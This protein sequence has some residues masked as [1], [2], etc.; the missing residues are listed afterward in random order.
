MKASFTSSPKSGGP[1]DKARF[2]EGDPLRDGAGEGWEG[3]IGMSVTFLPR[4]VCLNATS[5]VSGRLPESL[6]LGMLADRVRRIWETNRQ[7]SD[8][9]VD[10]SNLHRANCVM[11]WQAFDMRHKAGQNTFDPNDACTDHL[12]E[13]N[14]YIMNVGP[15]RV[16]HHYG[17]SVTSQLLANGLMTP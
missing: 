4:R 15:K 11:K 9:A 13:Y 16:L 17:I 8:T 6:S 2:F 7:A 5:K 14:H 1:G 3:C 12:S 10:G